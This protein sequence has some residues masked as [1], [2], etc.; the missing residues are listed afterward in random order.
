LLTLA[1]VAVVGGV[2]RSPVARLL[3][4]RTEGD[5]VSPEVH[6]LDSDIR[7]GCERWGPPF[8]PFLRP[9]WPTSWLT[10]EPARAL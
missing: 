7:Q 9:S 4:E 6:R 8:A 5:R 1:D 2:W 10:R 3:W